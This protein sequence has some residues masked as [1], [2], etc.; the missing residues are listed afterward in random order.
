MEVTASMH[1]ADQI[2]L[3]LHSMSFSVADKRKFNYYLG[4]EVEKLAR[5]RQRRQVDLEGNPWTP[6]KLSP[7]H[8]RSKG[9]ML[10]NLLKPQ[11]MLTYSNE[12]YATVT[13]KSTGQGIL[14]RQNQ[15]GVLKHPNRPKPKE[16]YDHPC[17]EKQAK[18]LIREGYRRPVRGG[19]AQRVSV[20]YLTENM[21][22]GQA[23]VVLHKMQN[24]ETASVS[25]WAL[26]ARSFLGAN[27][28]EQKAMVKTIAQRVIDRINAG[29]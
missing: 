1:G 3:V 21:T 9:K 29:R 5:T 27:Q 14:A 7:D 17:T 18:A 12:E 28:E 15:E 23:G 13:W 2:M 24:G 25:K 16:Y 22:I 11:R 10:K 20:K 8:P 4:K 26:P 19:N 6:R